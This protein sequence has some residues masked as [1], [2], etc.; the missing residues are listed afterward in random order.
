VISNRFIIKKR[1]K[2]LFLLL[3]VMASTIS[4]QPQFSKY[5]SMSGSF[6][7]MGFGARGMGMGNA[8]GAV[9]D[10]NLVSYYNPALSAFQEGNYF[11]TSYSFLSLD[12]S[13]NFLNFTRKFELGKSKEDESKPRSTAGLSV[14]IINAGVSDID[15]RD[16]QGE[17]FNTLSTSENQFFL[18]F[19]NRFSEKLSLGIGLKF[20]YYKLYE[21]ITSTAF[22]FDIGALYI[23]NDNL[24]FAGTITDINTKYKWDTSSIYGVEGNSTINKFP[25]LM[26]FASAY[27]FNDPNLL[28]TLEF[29]HSNAETD[30]LRI[31]IEYVIFKGLFLRSGIDR[32]SVGNTDLPMR[33]TFGFSYTKIFNSMNLGIDYAFVV[34]PYSAHDQ[35]IVGV[36]II[37]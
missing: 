11:Q 37:F 15:G 32:I 16:N 10:G 19:A 1:I 18:S 12:R 4:A 23:Y 6:S 24:T 26:K 17:K 28:A 2:E 20:Y 25:L 35:H 8:M 34:E 22:G 21:E 14:G 7:R 3:F 36:Q 31:G 9:I 33:P 5:N 27:K 30:F 13:L 29:E